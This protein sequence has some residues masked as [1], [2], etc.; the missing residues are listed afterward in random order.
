MKE[1]KRALGQL[2]NAMLSSQI[3]LDETGLWRAYLGV[4]DAVKKL[5]KTRV[6]WRGHYAAKMNTYPD[7]VRYWWEL[8]ARQQSWASAQFEGVGMSVYV[9]EIGTDGNV[10]CRRPLDPQDVTEEIPF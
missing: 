1:L 2:Q 9:Y 10:L 8:L 3:N 5:D 6:D 7:N 4:A